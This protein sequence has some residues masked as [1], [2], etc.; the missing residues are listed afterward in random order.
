[1]RAAE[2]RARRPNPA[3]NVTPL[4][5]VVLVLLIIFM[6]VAPMLENDVRVDIPSIFNIDPE[7]RGRTD[8]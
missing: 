6:V 1:M 4:V 7:S 2:R 3:M 8:P 5:D